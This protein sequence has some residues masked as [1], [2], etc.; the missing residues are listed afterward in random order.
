[1]DIRTER[2]IKFSL[3]VLIMKNYN[4]DFTQNNKAPDRN[5]GQ[6]IG[7]NIQPIRTQIVALQLLNVK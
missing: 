2:I 5:R 3:K 4:Q 1:M 6:C 7:C